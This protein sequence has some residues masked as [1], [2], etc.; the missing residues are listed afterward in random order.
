LH[1]SFNGFFEFWV[2][3]TGVA[4]GGGVEPRMIF[5]HLPPSR[6]HGPHSIIAG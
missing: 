1:Y 5:Y 4:I 3:G 6:A 2:V